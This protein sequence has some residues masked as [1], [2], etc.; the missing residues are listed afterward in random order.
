MRQ[1]AAKERQSAGRRVRMRRQKGGFIAPLVA[2]AAPLVYSKFIEAGLQMTLN[3]LLKAAA[4]KA[5]LFFVHR[6]LMN[7]KGG[8]WVERFLQWVPTALASFVLV[9]GSPFAGSLAI[10]FV[11]YMDAF[12]TKT[13]QQMTDD[14]T[15]SNARRLIDGA[16]T[17]K[18]TQEIMDEA[19]K[20][21][22]EAV[23]PVKAKPV[24]DK[25]ESLQA[26]PVKLR[27][28]KSVTVDIIAQPPEEKKKQKKQKKQTTE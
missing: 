22:I 1:S 10:V 6:V 3:R 13:S 5:G 20:I 26:V 23:K 15:M 7:Q 16:E 11:K 18:K 19:N 21:K 12:L 24:K 27:K 2:T 28:K 4:L 14:E 25:A 8:I 9:A 17:A